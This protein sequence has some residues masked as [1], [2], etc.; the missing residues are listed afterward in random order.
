ALASYQVLLATPIVGRR[1]LT[2]G[3][4]FVRALIRAGS[5]PS[6]DWTDAE[7]DVYADVLRSP[8]RAAASSACYRTFL[9]REVP[10]LGSARLRVPTLLAMGAESAIQRVLRPREEPNL[11]VESVPGAGHFIPEEAPEAVI[12]LARRWLDA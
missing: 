5:G 12:R 11:R 8:P 6:A 1:V 3:P 10:I 9:T 4:A 7:L 2:A